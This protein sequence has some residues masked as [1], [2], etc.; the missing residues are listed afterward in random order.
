[1]KINWE[2][3]NW[4]NLYKYIPALEPTITYLHEIKST[5]TEGKWYENYV[6]ILTPTLAYLCELQDYIWNK[7][8]ILLDYG[9]DILEK[10]GIVKTTKHKK[11][12]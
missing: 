7:I 11:M 3:I 9:L 8:E 1:M 4:K 12:S 5:Q 6:P 10:I 2:K